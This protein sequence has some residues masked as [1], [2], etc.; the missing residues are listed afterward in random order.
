[1][2]P[3][4]KSYI[5]DVQSIYIRQLDKVYYHLSYFREFRVLYLNQFLFQLVSL[6]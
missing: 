4:G 5:H 6:T 2:K 1:M 3:L